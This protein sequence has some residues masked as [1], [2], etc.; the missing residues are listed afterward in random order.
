M[1]MGKRSQQKSIAP[2]AILVAL[3]VLSYV[4][5]TNTQPRS[6][7]DAPVAS[8]ATHDAAC[9]GN[10]ALPQAFTPCSRAIESKSAHL[11]RWTD[12]ALTPRFSQSAWHQ[13]EQR[14][15]AYTG[16]RLETQ[17]AGGGWR[18]RT[19]FCAW[20]TTDGLVESAGIN[21]P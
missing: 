17:D 12:G 7:Q 21:G 1:S 13:P 10:S 19:Y 16:N 4:I 6:E 14:V 8:C 5:R 20:N 2:F 18:A 15:I 9:L 3:L 11:H